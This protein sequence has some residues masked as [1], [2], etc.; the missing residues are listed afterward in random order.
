MASDLEWPMEKDSVVNRLTSLFGESRGDHFHNGVDIASD[1]EPVGSVAKGTVLYSRYSSDDP[2]RN[3]FGTGNSVWI[4]HGKGLVS[5][6]YHLKEGRETGIATPKKIDTGEIIGKSGNTGHSSGS[7]LHFVIGMNYG[8][9]IIDPLKMLPDVPDTSEPK[10]GTLILTIGEKYSYVND[11]DNINI[12]KAFPVTVQIFDSG[13]KSGQRRGVKSVKFYHNRKFIK[14]SNFNE[15]SL[16]EN[17]WVNEDGLSFDELFFQGN[18]F[19]GNLNLVSG[20]NII[21]VIAVDFKGNQSKKKIAFN[22]TRI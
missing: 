19:I 5:A 22:V 3:E 2:F 9:K 8:K 12:S 21:E 7:H 16:K 6:Y 10:I 1:N 4:Y 17:S 11:G 20:E 13:M 18:Y 14:E 15:I